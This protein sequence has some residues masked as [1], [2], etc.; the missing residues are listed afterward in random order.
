MSSENT[1]S[2]HDT[3]MTSIGIELSGDDKRSPYLYWTPEIRKS[4]VKHCFIAGSGKS[5]TKLLFS[6]LTKIL[7]DIKTGL[8]KYCSAKTSHTGVNNVWIPHR[9][10]RIPQMYCHHKL[11]WES[12]KL[13]PFKHLI[14]LPCILPSHM[15]Y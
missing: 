6:L 11:T 4:P 3:F 14:F 1:V 12:V 2:T 8:E 15:I 10:V 7:I 13:L 5:N 9:Y